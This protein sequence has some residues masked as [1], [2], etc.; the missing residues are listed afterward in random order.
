MAPSDTSQRSL[1]G[2]LV[3]RWEYHPGSFLT[4]VWNHQRNALSQDPRATAESGLARLFSDPPVN[5]LLVKLSRRFGVR[6]SGSGVGVVLFALCYDPVRQKRGEG[7]FST[8]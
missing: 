8:T 6:G 3:L 2:D 7:K 5:V 1:K 4:A